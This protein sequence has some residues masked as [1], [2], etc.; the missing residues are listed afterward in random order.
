MEYKLNNCLIYL[1][2]NWPELTK[3]LSYED[4]EHLVMGLIDYFPLSNSDL[5][6]SLSKYMIRNNLNILVTHAMNKARYNP[7]YYSKFNNGYKFS[8]EKYFNYIKLLVDK[9]S[10][11]IFLMER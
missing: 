8:K 1:L 6:I 7:N 3:G 10:F 4:K 5:L 11:F 9:R 2:E